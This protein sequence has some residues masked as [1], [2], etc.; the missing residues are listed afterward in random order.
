MSDDNR[1]SLRMEPQLTPVRL[2]DKVDVNAEIKVAVDS[3]LTGLGVGGI[4]CIFLGVL[5]L[6]VGMMVFAY[7]FPEHWRGSADDLAHYSYVKSVAGLVGLGIVLLFLGT[8]MFFYGRTV[9][10]SGRLDQ[11][12]M[13]ES[14]GDGGES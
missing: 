13:Q 5:S 3:H 7:A 10:G 8:S 9:L 1:I 6:L 12:S 4:A 2:E 14:L 11:F